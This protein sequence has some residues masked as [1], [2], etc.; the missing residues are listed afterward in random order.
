MTF[1]WICWSID[2]LAL[3]AALYFFV[4]A[5]LNVRTRDATFFI[6][7][8]VLILVPYASISTSYWL[9]VYGYQLLAGLIAPYPRSL[10][11]Y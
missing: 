9:S 10:L 2:A 4:K 3:L 6:G 1:L 8:L 11:Y 7:W 5:V